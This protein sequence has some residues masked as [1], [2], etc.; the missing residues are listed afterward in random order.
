MGSQ[1]NAHPQKAPSLKTSYCSPH[2]A[3]TQLPSLYRWCPREER[4]RPVS[5]PSTSVYCSRPENKHQGRAWDGLSKYQGPTQAGCPGS[6][7]HLWCSDPEGRIQ[8][9]PMLCPALNIT[10]TLENDH[11]FYQ[12]IWYT[13]EDAMVDL[14]ICFLA[15]RGNM[16]WEQTPVHNPPKQLSEWDISALWGN[17]GPSTLQR[18]S[19][20]KPQNS[21]RGWARFQENGFSI[22]GIFYLNI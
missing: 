21:A 4:T 5:I 10:D 18:G 8:H 19:Q 22:K 20:R 16:N 15:G 13:E 6:D 12:H 1:S 7:G 9:L 17:E 3:Q 2:G 11:T 14:F